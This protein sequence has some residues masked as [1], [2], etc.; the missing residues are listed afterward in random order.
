MSNHLTRRRFLRTTVAQSALLAGAWPAHGGTVH[1]L[2]A[3]S[4]EPAKSY[5]A[6]NQIGLALIGAGNR[7]QDDTQ[8]ALGVPGVRLVAAAAS[9]R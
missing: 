8:T 3:A 5:A 6:S 1:M 2:D 9:N 7:G 4:A